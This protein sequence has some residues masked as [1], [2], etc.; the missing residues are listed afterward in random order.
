MSD[1]R[2]ALAA[3]EGVALSYRDQTG[4]DRTAPPET[5]ASILAAMGH[6]PGPDGS[7][8]A[9]LDADAARRAARILPDYRI[10]AE[11]S[12]PDLVP[13]GAWTVHFEDGRSAEGRGALP[14]LPLGRHRLE[15]GGETC[16]LL[17]APP[18]LP[19]PSR[20]WGVVLPLYG[21]RPAE[22]GGIGDFRDLETATR[23]VAS[24]GAG[25]AGINPIHAG[26]ATD[27][28]AI[29]PYSPSHR[30]RFATMHCHADGEAPPP[31]GPLIDY[32]PAK[33]ARL[34]ALERAYA[35]GPDE[36][37]EVWRSSEGEALERFATYEALAERFGPTWDRWP[38]AVRSAAYPEVS[39]FAAAHAGRVRFHA[40][41]QYLA[42]TQLSAVAAAA[43][44]AG[45]AQGLYLDLAVGTHPAGAETWCDP[46][47]FATG[48]SLGAPPDAFSE[49]G[50]VWHVAPFDPRALVRE[51]FAALAATLRVQLR[52]AGMLRIDHIL[53]FERAFWVPDGGTGTYVTMP[54]EAMLA[55]VRI[56]A[57]RAGAVIVGEDLG[58]IPKGLQEDLQASGILGCRV[59][60]FERGRKAAD[61][62]EA[63]L[64]SFGTHDLPTWTG[65]RE[66]RDLAARRG[67]GAMAA[68]DD[69]W[70]SD[71]R[72]AEVARI[73]TVL[74][75]APESPDAIHRHLGAT[76]SRLVAL[77]IED[78]L[79]V[80]DQPNLPGTVSE[81][82]NWRRRLPIGPT[83]F[84]ED[85]RLRTAARIMADAGRS[86]PDRA[87]GV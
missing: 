14:P 44:E 4:Q 21:L 10:V 54:R 17:S 38:L 76:P 67:I 20:G 15:A 65:W 68:E 51:G 43:R 53:G 28:D 11:G 16:W 87:G 41:L 59:A 13:E 49:T 82:P 80:A 46:G 26:F 12:V 47:P 39:A 30:R 35:A 34:A 18:A 45:M 86:G 50:Q 3:L 22:A 71:E 83:R 61:Y 1:A 74:G 60:M 36:G 73:D 27:P 58:N 48:V 40:W 5:V 23:A 79:G 84:A 24:L 32:P 66:G 31:G 57:A 55:V 2:E 75:D 63:V 37:F 77:Q 70:L 56:E 7:F 33:A 69:A 62:P 85:D 64:M 19:L 78:I 9:A 6:D 42:E 29:S 81:Y 25:F 8:E 72:R 52:H